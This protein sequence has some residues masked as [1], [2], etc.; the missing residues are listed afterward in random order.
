MATSPSMSVRKAAYWA[1][2]ACAALALGAAGAADLVRAPAVMEGLAHL[3]YPAYFATIR[4]TWEL[5]GAAAI[6]APD[7]PRLKERAYAGMFFALTG[8]AMSH[9]ISGDASAK[10]GPLVLLAAVIVSYS[11]RPARRAFFPAEIAAP[12]AA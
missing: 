2:T 3:G 4:G 5:L 9:A 7:R 6:L 8:A 11:T 10:I 1:S 12:R